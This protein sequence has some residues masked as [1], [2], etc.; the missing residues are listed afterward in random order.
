LARLAAKL[1]GYPLGPFRPVEAVRLHL[2]INGS[3]FRLIELSGAL[4]AMTAV[5]LSGRGQCS[6]LAVQQR[7][8]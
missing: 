4:T 2:A 7:I 8:E 1:G 6:F 3:E 5:L